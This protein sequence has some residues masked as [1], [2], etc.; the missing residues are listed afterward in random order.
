MPTSTVHRVLTCHRLNRLAF[1]DRTTGQVIRRHERDRPGE[2]VHIDVKK[3]GRT[4]DGGGHKVLGSG[5]VAFDGP[6]GADAAP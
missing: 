6:A 5:S 2:L 3:L 1:L 4:P